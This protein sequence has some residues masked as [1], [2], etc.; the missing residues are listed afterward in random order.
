MLAPT[1]AWQKTVPGRR[2][3]VPLCSSEVRA[4]AEGQQDVIQGSS[5]NI[6]FNM[7]FT[8]NADAASFSPFP[9]SETQFRL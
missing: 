9:V 8:Q 5:F 1:P 3:V 2:P 6:I 7:L 4:A